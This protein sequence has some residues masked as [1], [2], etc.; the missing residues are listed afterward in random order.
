MKKFVCTLFFSLMALPIIAMQ[1]I[2]A[3]GPSK[4]TTQVNAQA[5]ADLQAEQAEQAEP[6]QHILLSQQERENLGPYFG[7]L[8]EDLLIKILLL[9]DTTIHSIRAPLTEADKTATERNIAHQNRPTNNRTLVALRAVKFSCHGLHR[10]CEHI[11]NN[12]PPTEHI[13]N[14]GNAQQLG[15]L[16]DGMVQ[17]TGLNVNT[18]PATAVVTRVKFMEETPYF[19]VVWNLYPHLQELIVPFIPLKPSK[20]LCYLRILTIK[21]GDSSEKFYGHTRKASLDSFIQKVPNLEKAELETEVCSD[22]PIF[23][24]IHLTDLA[25]HRLV[26]INNNPVVVTASLKTTNIQQIDRDIFNLRGGPFF[27]DLQSPT[28]ENLILSCETNDIELLNILEHCPQLKVLSCE[29]IYTPIPAAQLTRIAN[30]VEQHNNLVTLN[31]GTMRIDGRPAIKAFFENQRIAPPAAIPHRARHHYKKFFKNYKKT[32]LLTATEA[33]SLYL[34]YKSGLLKKLW[35][36]ATVKTKKPLV[37]VLAFGL[38]EGMFIAATVPLLMVHVKE[39]VKADYSH[40]DELMGF[41]E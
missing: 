5:P 18:Y 8:S 34:L 1:Q 20:D 17:F 15:G 2:P 4:P 26:L 41:A 37:N 38:L 35:K 19:Y 11:Y 31:I 16:L 10:I 22:S 32:L 21:G 33:A 36:Y 29:S 13:F 7:H 12:Y 25:C 24:L 23:S 27:F 40:L 14:A 6:V 28:L 3:Q 30:A 9:N 39:G